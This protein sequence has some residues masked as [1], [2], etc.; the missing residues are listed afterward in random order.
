MPPS[1]ATLSGRPKRN[2]AHLCG[3]QRSLRKINFTAEVAENTQRAAEQ[4]H[5]GTFPGFRANTHVCRFTFGA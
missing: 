5:F 1:F 4:R 3:S 2:S